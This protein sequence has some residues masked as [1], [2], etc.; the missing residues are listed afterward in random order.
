MGE[1]MKFRRADLK[2]YLLTGFPRGRDMGTRWDGPINHPTETDSRGYPALH[3]AFV[4]YM[5]RNQFGLHV[6][7]SDLAEL[8]DSM[9]RP[10]PQTMTDERLAYLH[11]TWTWWSFWRMQGMTAEAFA[12]R[13][14]VTERTVYRWLTSLLRHIEHE[15]TKPAQAKVLV[16]PSS[17][18]TAEVSG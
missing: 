10:N 14:G 13:K 1:I 3:P 4:D 9:A 15:M 17:Y 11:A 2:E 7:Y 8:Y 16:F 18:S 5:D 12:E 6:P